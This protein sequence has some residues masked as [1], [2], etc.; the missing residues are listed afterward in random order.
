MTPPQVQ[1][2]GAYAADIAARRC[3]RL[4]VRCWRRNQLQRAQGV[5]KTKR[6]PVAASRARPVTTLRWSGFRPGFGARIVC[7]APSAL[8]NGASKERGLSPGSHHAGAVQTKEV[9]VTPKARL[10]KL[11]GA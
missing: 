2:V 3:R 6:E 1:Y 11:L 4:P 8:E 7:P 10:R 5:T 9:V